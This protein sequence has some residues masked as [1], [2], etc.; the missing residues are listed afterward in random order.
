MQES[1]RGGAPKDDSER[2]GGGE[3]DATSKETLDDLEK[4]EKLPDSKSERTPDE[5][6]VPSPDGTIDES[7]EQIDDAGPM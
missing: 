3:S 2:G 5:S 4:S 7:R 1:E 6:K